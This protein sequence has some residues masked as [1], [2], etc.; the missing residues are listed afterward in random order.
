MIMFDFKCDNGHV[1][2]G[3]VKSDTKVIDCHEC[4]QPSKKQIT[5]VRC[6]IDAISGD[7]IKATRKWERNRAEKLSQ[8]RKANS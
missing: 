2:E 8:E 7:S 4:G 5:P 6:K 1:T 3:L